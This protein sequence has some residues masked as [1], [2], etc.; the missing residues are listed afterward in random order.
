LH[1][2]TIRRTYGEGC[3]AAHALDL[4][5]ERWALLIVRELLLG[6]K[7]FTDLRAGVL[8]ASANL[9]SQRLRELED[10]GVVQRRT[11]PPPA[12]SRVYELTAWGRGLEPVLF[13]LGRWGS[14]SPH[15]PSETPMSLD[16]QILALKTLFDPVAAGDLAARYELVLGLERFTIEISLGRIDVARAPATEPAATVKTDRATLAD[17]V[18]GH[19]PLDKAKESGRVSIE[20]DE[21]AVAR[22]LTL[23]PLPTP[24]GSRG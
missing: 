7:R 22:L 4:I 11:L 8:N 24:A 6:P 5:G 18:F 17:L 23:F 21:R 9:L 2:V 19:L 14:R 3:A 15:L 13:H 16:S 10:A 1:N 12:G 20:G